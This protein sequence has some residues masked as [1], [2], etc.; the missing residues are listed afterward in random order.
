MTDLSSTAASHSAIANTEDEEEQKPLLDPRFDELMQKFEILSQKVQLNEK[1]KIAD[2]TRKRADNEK[3]KC[4]D[5]EDQKSLLD[6]CLNKMMKKIEDLNLE[7]KEKEDLTKKRER[8]LVK[9]FEELIKGKETKGKIVL[10]HK[11]N[12]LV[13]SFQIN[14]TEKNHPGVRFDELM[15]KVEELQKEKENLHELISDL[16]K[17][18]SS[19]IRNSPNESPDVVNFG[20]ADENLDA[21]ELQISDQTQYAQDWDK[22]EIHLVY[23]IASVFTCLLKFLFGGVG[24]FLI[25]SNRIAYWVVILALSVVFEMMTSTFERKLMKMANFA[26]FIGWALCIFNNGQP[27]GQYQNVVGATSSY[28]AMVAIAAL[29]LVFGQVVIVIGVMKHQKSRLRKAAYIA[30]AFTSI[31]FIYIR[32]VAAPSF[33]I[34]IPGWI[35]FILHPVFLFFGL[36]ASK[37]YRETPHQNH[38]TNPHPSNN[39]DDS[40]SHDSMQPNAPLTSSNVHHH[41]QSGLDTS[42]TPNA[43]E[44]IRDKDYQLQQETISLQNALAISPTDQNIPSSYKQHRRNRLSILYG[45]NKDANIKGELE[46]DMY[47]MMMLSHWKHRSFRIPKWCCCSWCRNKYYVVFV[48]LPSKSWLM[49]FAVFSV[50]LALGVLIIADQVEDDF[51]ATMNIP[52]RNDPVVRIGQFMAVVLALFSQTDITITLYNLFQLWYGSKSQWNK[53]IGEEHDTSFNLWL[54]R[55]FVPN[56]LK[57]SQ[58]V[59]ILIASIIIIL[60][61]SDIVELLK[62]FTA[63]FVISS[64]DDIF[65]ILS[66]HGY[67]GVDLSKKSDRLIAIEIREDDEKIRKRLQVILFTMIGGL[68]GWWIYVVKGQINGRYFAQIYPACPTNYP[69]KDIDVNMN[70]V[71]SRRNRTYFFYMKNDV[72]DF[73]TGVGPNVAVCGWEGGDCMDLNRNF[74]KYP[75][76]PVSNNVYDPFTEVWKKK[77]SSFM[78]N[79]ICDFAMGVGP[80]IEECGWEG[81]DCLDFNQQYPNCTESKIY[82]IQNGQCDSETNIEECGFDGNDCLEE[83]EQLQNDYP[84]CSVRSP[85]WI[86]DGICDGFDYNTTEC[87]WDGGDCL[88]LQQEFPKCKGEKSDIGNGICGGR[89]DNTKEC[90]WDGGDCFDFNMKYPFCKTGFPLIVGDGRCHS[91]NNVMECGWDGGDCVELNEKYPNCDNIDWDFGNGW[92]SFNTPECGFDDGD[93]NEDGSKVREKYPKCSVSNPWNIGNGICNLGEY[94]VEECGFDGGDCLDFNQKYPDC[95]A[96]VSDG[97]ARVGDGICHRRESNVE[98]CGY[99]DGEC[100]EFNQKYPKCSVSEPRNIGNGVCNGGGYNVE[101]CGFDGGDCAN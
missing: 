47:T 55:I 1:E 51:A 19:L 58:G 92:C 7:F 73:P 42:E 98:E 44:S 41:D 37:S 101:E 30:N 26:T 54:G 31:L 89:R 45:V 72:C 76:C 90:G 80:N 27:F 22:N 87:G 29:L 14:E 59:I 40:A 78:D 24:Y 11:L 83:N 66:D 4:G 64:V 53:V 57:I 85:S 79:I 33:F 63:L 62:D 68:L 81:G 3:D 61:S 52:P 67:F 91:Q 100:L 25:L 96:I 15:K 95:R 10:E 38:H 12:D 46:R 97:G 39:P 84:N 35:S 8:E 82:L 9:K 75:S 28:Q 69:I 50:Q 70:T 34:L 36:P 71:F 60:Q 43:N 17:Q 94:N 56:V 99:E 6:P 5:E 2:L 77:Y 21:L 49:G 65:F 18:V 88:V 86:G 74:M 13:R 48:P 20:R 93:C 32:C 23:D 16:Q